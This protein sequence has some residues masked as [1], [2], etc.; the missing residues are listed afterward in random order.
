[1]TGTFSMSTSSLIFTGPLLCEKLFILDQKNRILDKHVPFLAR[2]SIHF[3]C[4]LKFHRIGGDTVT[5]LFL[6]EVTI[7]PDELECLSNDMPNIR[8][9]A[10]ESV[11]CGLYLEGDSYPKKA[12]PNVVHCTYGG[13]DHMPLF[14]FIVKGTSKLEHL[15]TY[16]GSGI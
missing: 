4:I 3:S 2:F 12:F 5:T 14:D 16:L 13:S 10:F 6:S 8:E 7:E 11:E 1:M 15:C 9:L